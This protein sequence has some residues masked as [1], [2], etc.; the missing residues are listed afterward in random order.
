MIFQRPSKEAECVPVRH[1]PGF[2]GLVDMRVLNW[3]QERS[4][5]QLE[6]VDLHFL[7]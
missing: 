2:E 4:L 6:L 5:A 7:D 3:N 1:W